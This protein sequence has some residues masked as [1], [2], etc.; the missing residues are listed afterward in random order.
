MAEYIRGVLA[1]AK[2]GVRAR[3]VTAAVLQAG[4]R[5]RDKTFNKTV[6]K[7]LASDKRFRRV[8]RGIYKLAA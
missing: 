1:K 6:A 8:S 7:M 2:E 3:D 5:T 4:Y